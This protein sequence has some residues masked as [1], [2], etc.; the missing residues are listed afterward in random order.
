MEPCE[1]VATCQV[2]SCSST[3]LL[4]FRRRLVYKVLLH[5]C[6]QPS[7]YET[8]SKECLPTTTSLPA[9]VGDAGGALQVQAA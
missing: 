3:D 2:V 9:P 5:L 6:M 1:A 8:R 7:T 4:D